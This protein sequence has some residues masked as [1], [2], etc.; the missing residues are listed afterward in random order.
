M[1]MCGAGDGPAMSEG[2]MTTA[3]RNISGT[4]YD[5]M[6]LQGMYFRQVC[7]YLVIFSMFYFVIK[8]KS[9]QYSAKK[10]FEQY[11][12]LFANKQVGGRNCIKKK[13]KT[14]LKT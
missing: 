8:N 2:Q 9:T 6:G 14:V 1:F 13:K 4:M 11:C 10:F 3:G 12:F 5:N 7:V